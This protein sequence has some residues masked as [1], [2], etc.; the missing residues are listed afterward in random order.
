MKRPNEELWAETRHGAWSGKG[1][2]Y[3]DRFISL[4]LIKQW[5][6]QIPNGYIIPEG[7]EDVV[8]ELENREIWVQIKSLKSG[9]FSVKEVESIHKD[10]DDKIARLTNEKTFEVAIGLQRPCT[11]VAIK[12][13]EHL[14]SN[15]K[16]CIVVSEQPELEAISILVERLGVA[17]AIAENLFNGVSARVGKI[18]DDNGTIVFD[19]RQKISTTDIERFILNYLETSDSS[20]IDIAFRKGVI[21]P[22]DFKTPVEDPAFYSGVKAQ[23]GHIASGLIIDRPEQV[24]VIVQSFKLVRQVIVSGPSGAGKSS[25]VWLCANRMAKATRWFRI[26]SSATLDE[27]K[28][29]QRFVRARNPNP[30]SSIGLVCD[31]LNSTNIAFWHNLN[32]EILKLPNVILLGAVRKEDLSNLQGVRDAEIISVELDE[33]LAKTLWQEL[34]KREKT[35]WLHWKEPF[36]QSNGLL[37]EYTHIL[38]QGKRL[39]ILLQEQV[40][41]RENENR[42]DELRI[43]R[44]ASLITS[45]NGEVEVSILL[46]VLEISPDK[47]AIALK[48]LLNEHLVR[49]S[50]P[51]VLGGLH[52]LRSNAL[53]KLTHDGL[54]LKEED[55]FLA[56]LNAV[57]VPTLAQVIQLALKDLTRFDFQKLNDTLLSLQRTNE[58]VEV[59]VAILQGLGFAT[60]EKRAKQFISLLEEMNIER[61]LWSV[62][63]MLSVGDKALPDLDFAEN[64]GR[65]KNVILQFR[66]Q[67][68][69]DYRQQFCDQLQALPNLTSISELHI[70][71]VSMIGMTNP[72]SIKFNIQNIDQGEV[73]VKKIVRVL[74]AAYAV[75]PGTA[76]SL[77]SS[78][79]GEEQ[80]MRDVASQFT[81][82]TSPI[83]EQ[84][85]HGRTV[86]ADYYY[87]SDQLKRDLNEVA[88]EICRTLLAIV[89]SAEAAACSV[90]NPDGSIVQV[91]D[92]PLMTKDIPRENLPPESQVGWNRIFCQ[93]I[94]SNANVMTLTEY[95]MTLSEL[96]RRT[97]SV[98]N[99]ITE[100]WVR[101]SKFHNRERLAEECNAISQICN[102]LSFT[103]VPN[104]PLTIHDAVKEGVSTDTAGTLLT[105]I[106]NN[107]VSRLFSINIETDARGLAGFTLNLAEDAQKQANSTIWR[108]LSKDPVEQ[109]VALS[110][111]LLNLAQVLQELG[112][113]N[114]KSA[115]DLLAG[116]ATRASFGRS[117]ASAS[118]FCRSRSE[119][120]LRQKLEQLILNLAAEGVK[121]EYKTRSLEKNEGIYWP[122]VEVLLI[123]KL[124]NLNE[125]A[126]LENILQCCRNGMPGNQAF[127]VAFECGRKIIPGMAF[128][129]YPDSFFP[130]L[131]FV[132]DWGT[133]LGGRFL[134]SEVL[135]AFDKGLASIFDISS[136]LSCRDIN[137]YSEEDKLLSNAVEQ[138]RMATD[139]IETILQKERK[140]AYL[141]ALQYLYE[142]FTRLEDEANSR[143]NGFPILSSMSISPNDVL[144]GISTEL[145]QRIALVRLTIISEELAL[146]P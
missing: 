54:A 77:C 39:E 91:K 78:F 11:S 116:M 46:E 74:E 114:T 92:F 48:R 50:V 88:V 86:R 61:S 76:G 5:A 69:E 66:R 118:K 94:L 12:G 99:E 108:V 10:I 93:L 62:A 64:F 20:A 101:G 111:R 107:L 71:L 27:V 36:E 89:P 85:T 30:D 84:G 140:D 47:G 9:S 75:S 130:D 18:S 51:G 102:E 67:P 4:L 24:E 60:A 49:E 26:G 7:F 3:Q 131:N 121:A 134:H 104:V 79:G 42:L 119:Q 105:N 70:V 63:S 35:N 45:L 81:W 55:T 16:Q 41:Q 43:L 29:I 33:E 37:L 117:L 19:D 139:E 110:E 136:I 124:L 28:E 126:N 138:F 80:L 38:T 98:F 100:K 97:E 128:K 113:D 13:V 68:K 137:F 31:E 112:T 83:I 59:L 144:S 90:I 8:L 22:V 120:R 142:F 52:S 57:S 146:N 103:V 44:A 17:E 56:T 6:G 14:L 122:P 95:A 23:P 32:E 40:Q 34:Q 109:L 141:W 96:I 127:T 72:P 82:I 125:L 115:R 123:V 135:D 145:T 15:S 53:A 132:G 106:L 2:R 65:I 133:E 1:Y 25:L 58:K 21:E 143:D 129:V 87:V 73:D